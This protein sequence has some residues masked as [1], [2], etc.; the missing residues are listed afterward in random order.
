MDLDALSSFVVFSEKRNFT[1][2]AEELNISQ[3]ALHVKIRKLGQSLG[4]ELYRRRGRSL[5]VTRAG[6][7]LARF[8]REIRASID[9]FLGTLR[10][11]V[12]EQ[13]VVLAAGEGAILYLLA[14]AIRDFAASGT[15]LQILTRDRDGAVDALRSGEAHV[16]VVALDAIPADLTAYELVRA[17]QIVVMPS[18]HPLRK[19][20]EIALADLAGSA[21]IVPPAGRPHRETVVRAL[22]DA[23]VPWRVAVEA[24]GWPVMLELVKSG[25]GLA[26]V[27]S[28]CALPGGL[29]GRPLRGIPATHYH[30]LHA[31]GRIGADARRFVT[32]I[33][34]ATRA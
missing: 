7:E 10:G 3:P 19:K 17:R 9:A 1:H 31:R 4:V 25:V 2:A 13:P 33:R 18:R 20:A 24:N 34:D 8:G 6:R 16:G 21:L 12:V 14:S 32:M 29:I 22:R 27:N 5:E 23:G 28:T 15:P 26:I 30:L 11:E